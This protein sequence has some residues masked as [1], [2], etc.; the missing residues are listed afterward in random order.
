MALYYLIPNTEGGKQLLTSG[1][2]AVSAAIQPGSTETI[3]KVKVECSKKGVIFIQHGQT[4][5]G[6]W[7]SYN[8]DDGITVDET[9]MELYYYIDSDQYLRTQLNNEEGDDNYVKI[10][11]DT[12]SDPIYCKPAEVYGLGGVDNS[13]VGHSDVMRWI[14]MAT[15]EVDRI[16]GQIWDSRS[17]TE[18]F[19]GNNTEFY[20]T[21]KFPVI[22]V[23]SL[24]IN[25]TTITVGNLEIDEEV[26]RIGLDSGCETGLFYTDTNGFQKNTIVYTYGRSTIPQ[27]IRKLTACIAAIMTLTEQTGGTYDDVT[28]FTLGTRTISVGEPW[29]NIENAMKHLQKM[30]DTLMKQIPK[31]YNVY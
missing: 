30:V 20:H 4:S 5:T 11:V 31:P 29:V 3:N 13:V 17:A 21:R 9:E 28:S 27:E 24:D 7:S 1:Q 18:T 10:W 8:P 26:G 6:P 16:T 15:A 12:D 25:G 2:S 22:S 14:V 23:T 19:N